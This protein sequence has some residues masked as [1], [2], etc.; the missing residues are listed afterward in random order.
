MIRQFIA[1]VSLITASPII[2]HDADH[3]NAAGE[4]AKAANLFLAS[5][6]D[7][8]RSMAT[9]K[10]TDQHREEWYFIPDKFIKPAGKRKGLVIKDMQQNQR[11]LAHALLATAMSNKGYGQATTT[12]TLESILHE[13]ENKNPIRDPELY[14]V[15]VFGTPGP[16]KTWAW[17]FEGHHL[18]INVAVAKGEAFSVTP[19]FFGTNPARS[20]SGPFKGLE[21]LEHEQ[22]L[23]LALV[24][25]LNAEQLKLA[26][27]AAK[28]P[29]DIITKQQPRA[30]RKT[31]L[32][33]KGIPYQ[34]LN[35]K[36]QGMLLSLLSHYASKYRPE[37]VDEINSRKPIDGN[38]KLHFAWAGGHERNTGHYYRIQSKDF[39]FEYDNTQNGANHVHAVWRDFDGDFGRDLLKEHHKGEH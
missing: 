22:E 4:M 9:F 18:S 29:A 27:L 36:Q 10:L 26:T 12:M 15:S 33:V 20:T 31:F 16:E 30:N 21:V 6:N 13:L 35:T 37:I 1:F 11:L 32:P 19:S 7:K 17:R 25:S 39:L 23:A 3:E 2:A 14:Y 8:Q 38:K 28:A 5:L 24:K 34:T